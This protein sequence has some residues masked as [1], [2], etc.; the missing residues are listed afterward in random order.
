MALALRITL[1]VKILAGLALIALFAVLLSLY[2]AHRFSYLESQ[3]TVVNEE[4]VPLLKNLNQIEGYFYPYEQD[5]DHA[6]LDSAAVKPRST[7]LQLMDAKISALVG[8]FSGTENLD[9]KSGLKELLYSFSEM[10]GTIDSVFSDPVRQPQYEEALSR[11]RG[12]FKHQLKVLIRDVDREIRLA[13]V[14]M[15]SVISKSGI[16]LTFLIAL[17]FITMLFLGYWIRSA[18]RP[19]DKLTEKV[20]D[21]SEYGLS[22]GKL[23]ELATIEPFPKNELGVFTKEFSKMASRLLDQT[24][25]LEAQKKNLETAHLEMGKQNIALKKTKTQLLHKEKLALVGQLTAQMAHEIRNPLNALGLHIEYM[26]Q[27]LGPNQM[28]ASTLNAVKRE[29]E[30]LSQI[31]ETYLHHARAPQDYIEQADLNILI[32]EAIELYEPVLKEKGITC[33]YQLDD[34]PPAKVDRKKILQVFSNLIKNSYESL[35]GRASKAKYIRIFSK[36]N[37]NSNELE[38]CFKDNGGGIKSSDH[39]QIFSPFFTTKTDGTGL[40]LA[41]SKQIMD[42][43][44]GDISFESFHGQ[45]TS[46]LLKLPVDEGS[47]FV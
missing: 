5:L 33:T 24:K 18:L 21:I 44:G 22:E 47:R 27:E 23:E 46:F 40:G 42:E 13:S 14:D 32:K 26:E 36:F 17:C 25:Q 4:Y 38:L 9:L 7:Q 6:L 15:Q 11:A 45:G 39:D 20:R 1:K 28:V 41:Q 34:L 3:L 19:L 12:N 29:I 43:Y 16:V 2:C 30:R 35:D 8:Q 31:T 10:N 37:P